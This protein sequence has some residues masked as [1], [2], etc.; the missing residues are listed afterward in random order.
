MTKKKIIEKLTAAGIEVDNTLKLGE[1]EQLA[2]DSGIDLEE[3]K[4]AVGE[5]QY[6][7]VRHLAEGG[8]HYKPGDLIALTEERAAAMGDI[9]KLEAAE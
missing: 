7:V 1:L 9:V 4:T 2:I 5:L 8:V 6:S 3:G